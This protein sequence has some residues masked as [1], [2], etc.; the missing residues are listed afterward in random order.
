MTSKTYTLPSGDKIRPQSQRR[1]ILVHES[2]KGAFIGYRSDVLDR[3]KVHGN[4]R[5]I[6]IDQV[7]GL[8]RFVAH[9]GGD[10]ARWVTQ[11]EVKAM[12]TR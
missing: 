9:Q 10:A 11:D 12:V 6:I 8:I 4:S 1:F 3:V 7:T 2:T 5:D